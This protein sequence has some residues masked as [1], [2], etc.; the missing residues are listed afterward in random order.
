MAQR[1]SQHTCLLLTTILWKCLAGK[2]LFVTDQQNVSG[3]EAVFSVIEGI[4]KHE[5]LG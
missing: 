3:D 5:Y 2:C 1:H 4:F